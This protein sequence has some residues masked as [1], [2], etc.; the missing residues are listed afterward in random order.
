MPWHNYIAAFFAGAFLANVVPHFSTE[1][2]APPSRHLREKMVLADSK[3]GLGALQLACRLHLA[4]GR[5]GLERSAS[6]SHCVSRGS[7]P[8]ASWR[9]GALQRKNPVDNEGNPASAPLRKEHRALNHA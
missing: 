4:G 9:V 6:D 5:E 3:R 7:Q 8:L 2:R 1:S